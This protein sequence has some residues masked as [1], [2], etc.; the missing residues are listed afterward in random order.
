MASPAPALAPLSRLTADEFELLEE[1]PGFIQ[2]LIEGVLVEMPR[3]HFGHQVVASA[4]HLPLA[5]FTHQA[6]IGV[7]MAE[8]CYRL[9]DGNEFIPDLSVVFM[10]RFRAADRKQIFR[11]APDIA[12]EVVSS[13][14]ALRLEAKLR[15]YLLCG[16]KSVWTVF[17]DFRSLR[18]HR[19]DGAIRNY[20]ETDTLDDPSLPGIQLPLR[21]LF[22]NLQSE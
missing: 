19:S 14:P 3:S 11:G 7:T 22:A 20:E 9:D 16:A 15:A 6:N 13:E 18:A 2:E 17:P 4:I 10:D 12:I 21:E 5:N 1:R 8:T